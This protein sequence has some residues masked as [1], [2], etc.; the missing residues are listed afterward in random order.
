MLL[1]LIVFILL[2]SVLVFV[3]ELGHFLM[4]K[5]T[6]MR[7]DEF[8]IGFPPRLYSKRVGDTLYSVNWILLGGYVKIHGEDPSAQAD[9]DTRSYANK[10]VWARILVI[11][12]GVGMNLLFAFLVLTI[13]FS[14]GF[15]SGSQDLAAVPGAVVKESQV[16]VV[17]ELP[18]S[19]ISTTP[20]QPGDVIT[21]I[22]DQSGS[23]PIPVDTVEGLQN[24]L[25][26]YLQKGDRNVTI[27]YTHNQASYQAKVRLNP[28][29]PALGVAIDNFN[30]VRVP[31]WRAPGVAAK[32]I[33]SLSTATWNALKN[34][35]DQL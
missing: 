31:V 13:A 16:Y 22:A 11:I 2:L 4:A 30:T 23:N 32:E 25:S 19:P 9:P 24:A 28:T 10:P 34:F 33:G 17:S 18:H 21:G 6:G 3:H 26:T 7:V 5:W 15:V 14:V 1:S 27:L 35:A 20:V 12:S 29:G 8:N